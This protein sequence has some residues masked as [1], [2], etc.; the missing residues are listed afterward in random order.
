VIWG[1]APTR[2]AATRA[3]VVASPLGEYAG[4]QANS[5]AAFIRHPIRHGVPAS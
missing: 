2:L 1:D 3:L 5:R 4:G